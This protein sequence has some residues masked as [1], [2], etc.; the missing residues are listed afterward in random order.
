MLRAVLLGVLSLTIVGCKGKD[1]SPTSQIG[2]AAGKAIEVSGTVTLHHGSE[3][4]AL[5]KGDTVE[6]DDVIETGADGSVQ[7]ELAHNNATW[8]LGAN[9]KVKVRE[10]LA[11]NEAKKDKSAKAVEQDSAAAGRHAEKNAADTTVSAAAPAA[12]ET[13]PGPAAAPAPPQ[14]KQDKIEREEKKEEK[15]PPRAAAAP[16][17]QPPPPAPTMQPP[18]KAAAAPT[19]PLPAA[20][21]APPPP[22]PPKTE[23]SPPPPKTVTRPRSTDT[24]GGAG[25]VGTEGG[26]GVGD[27]I[28]MGGAGG[29]V[30]GGTSAMVAARTQ[31]NA[32]MAELKKCFKDTTKVTFKVDAQGRVTLGYSKAVDADTQACVE[33]VT[34]TIELA[35]SQTAVTVEIKP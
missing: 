7:I 1:E 19:M 6:G 10:S 28:G 13:M 23:A 30:G 2:V 20:S 12:T 24:F 14:V 3:S 21:A 27:G 29:K 4:R 17:V 9:K 18:P 11:W 25:L 8:E 32:H 22:P 16:Q 5:A 26:G 33:R 35:S 15:A 34:K 31:I